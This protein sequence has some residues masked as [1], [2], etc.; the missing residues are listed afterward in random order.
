MT[1]VQ[2]CAFRSEELAERPHEHGPAPEDGIGL[3]LEDEV[4]AHDLDT[5][6]GGDRDDPLTVGCR[7]LT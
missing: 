7:M 5:A 1:G 2:T 6:L 3:V 4:G